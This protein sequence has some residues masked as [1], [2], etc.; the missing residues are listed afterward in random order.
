MP[1]AISR[2]LRA[3]WFADLEGYVGLTSSDEVEALAIITLLQDHARAAVERYG[4]EVVKFVGDGILASFGSTESA[5]RSALELGGEFRKVTADRGTEHRLRIGIHVGDVATS[6]DGDVYGDG[7]NVASRLEQKAN[8][9]QAIISEDVWRQLRSRKDFRFTPLGEHGLK[10]VDE[11]LEL[12]VVEFEREAAVAPLSER[13]WKARRRPGALRRVARNPRRALGLALTI[14]V[15]AAGVWFAQLGDGIGDVQQASLVV[16][17]FDNLSGDA[18]RQYLVA[19]MHDALIGR[20]AQIGGLRV[21]SRT[22]A[23]QYRDTEK[24]LPQ[25]AEELG[26]DRVVEATVLRADDSVRVRIQLIQAIP[27]EEHL[28][29]RSYDGSVVD[30]PALSSDVAL[31]IARE[32]DVELTSEE[33]SRLATVRTVDPEIY[34]EYLR[35]MFYLGQQTPEGF[36]RGLLHLHNAV[37]LDPANAR[38]YAGL[39]LGYSLIGHATIPDAFVRAEAAAM[40]ALELEPNLAEANEALAEIKLYRTF[41]WRGA[42]EALERVIAVKPGFAQAHAHYAWYL[43]ILSRNEDA[44]ASMERAVALDP[45]DPV[46]GAWLA[47]IQLEGR[48]YDEAIAT[49]TSALEL[50][51]TH[52]HTLYVLAEASARAGMTDQAVE[53]ASR[54][55]P[56]FRWG[57]AHVYAIIGRTDDA[58]AL[59]DE[60]ASEPGP[61]TMWGLAAVHAELG[62]TDEGMRWLEAAYEA[63]MSWMPWIHRWEAFEP[64]HDHPGF[65]DLLRRLDLAAA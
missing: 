16:L 9:G 30:V 5:V 2:R 10:G 42:G 7:I 40:R 50:D 34:E 11:P 60:L 29:V 32:I 36:E 58:R 46:W 63:G 25:I 31:A 37:E 35:G 47:W 22:S 23:M 19:G 55:Q 17:P 6:T 43:E 52:P 33:E 3:V 39:A 65:Q 44:V 45:L 49:A 24:S 13:Q 51:P 56:P 8:P 4:G 57:L 62:N 28:W 53:T 64:L 27:E 54:L 15:V 61:V 14:A 59:A 21:I 20:L 12:F 1:Q 48:H 41:D 18:E 26:V 38:A